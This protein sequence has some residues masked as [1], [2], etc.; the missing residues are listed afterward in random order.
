[1]N[2]DL[3]T[4]LKA[5]LAGRDDID[6]GQFKLVGLKEIREEAGDAWARI[7]VR[8][9]TAA[10]QLIERELTNK[11]VV[12][13]AGDGFLVVL[14]DPALIVT[15]RLDAI[16]E[17]LREFFLGSPE[18]QAMKVETGTV[19]LAAGAL[20]ALSEAAAARPASKPKQDKDEGRQ[21]P[22]PSAVAPEDRGDGALSSWFR[23]VWDGKNQQIMGNA[24][25]PKV[26]VG[27]RALDGRRVA[28]TRMAPVDQAA[29]DHMAQN[30]GFDA[31]MRSVKAK[32]PTQICLSIHA[33]TWASR[34]DRAQILSRFDSLPDTVRSAFLVRFDGMDDSTARAKALSELAET[35]VGL[36]AEI[37]FGDIDLSDFEDLEI[38]L[39]GW[40]CKPPSNQNSAGLM[41]HDMSALRRF[42]E[43]AGQLGADTYLQDVR[44]LYVLKSARESG[45]RYFSG[46]AVISDRQV[47]APIQPLSMV[48]IYR[49]HKAA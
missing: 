44:D 9:F 1:M 37:P 13:Q 5:A 23:P 42:V 11:D 45:I 21:I 36:M 18:T 26:W 16:A 28:E 6:V 40:R 7:K 48:D 10:G 32:K 22:R 33:E 35:G 38:R 27:G 8:V 2:T 29:L 17:R 20:T 46:Q 3:K 24:C 15:D 43:A 25:R 4:R 34:D 12:L 14:S 39:F 31:L 41:D 30:A 19:K 49:T 47:P